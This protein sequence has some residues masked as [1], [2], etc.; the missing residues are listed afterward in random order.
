MLDPV[1]KYDLVMHGYLGTLVGLQLLTD[2]FRQ[3]TQKVLSR[4]EIYVVGSPENH[5]AYTDRG[6]V[7]S[8]PTSGADQ[9]NTS[10]GWLLSEMFSFIL[11]NPRSV[12][13]GRRV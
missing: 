5:G 8:T 9:G 13:K 3:P 11:A 4:G 2:A 6:G 12:A 10:K 7:R 1:T